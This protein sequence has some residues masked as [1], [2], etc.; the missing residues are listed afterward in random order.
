ML[1]RYSMQ[2][3]T[4]SARTIDSR[5]RFEKPQLD[6]LIDIERNRCIMC[7]R[8]VR[9][10]DEVA[11]EHLLG[12]FGRGDRNHIGT[13]GN[14]PVDN[15]FS[16]NIIDLCP[17]GC[18]TSKPF[19]FQARAWELQQVNST[20]T[21]C[22][23]GC[24][25]TAW[26]RDGK[27]MRM[28]PPVRKYGSTF[29]IDEDTTAFLCNEGRFG[30]YG[31]NS[32]D[33]ITQALR[34]EGDSVVIATWG[35]AFEQASTALAAAAKLGPDRVAILAGSRATNEEYFLLSQIART[36]LGTNQIDWRVDYATPDGA[37]AA[38]AAL[39]ASNGDLDLLAKGHYGATLV[40]GA[41]LYQGAPVIGLKIKEATRQGLTKLGILGA[42]HDGWA[43]KL[44]STAAYQTP[45]NWAGSVTALADSSAVADAD[46]ES[47]RKLA[48]DS[49]TGLIV[50]AIDLAGGALAS[51]LVPAAL[52]LADSLG[53][54]WHF[55]PVFHGRNAKGA[56]ACGA[57]SDR[58]PG[59][60]LDEDS[61]RN[62]LAELGSAVGVDAKSGL[63]APEI[64][65]RAA[66][67]K[68]DTLLLHRCDE[69]AN[70]PNQALVEKALSATPNVIIID[71]FPSAV[72]RKASV[73]LPAA[74]FF[75]TDGSMTS[76]DGTLNSL[77]KANT[78]PGEAR[79]EWRTLVALAAALGA[80]TRYG[81]AEE[82]FSDLVRCWGA[83]ARLRLG[84]LKLDGPGDESP[85]RPQPTVI[86]KRT[87]PAFKLQYTSAASRVA[88]SPAL[89]ETKADANGA[90]LRLL[91]FRGVQGGDQLGS[92]CEEFV[93]LRPHD[94]IELHPGDAS[95][96]EFAE[97]HSV[98]IKG[99]ENVLHVKLNPTLP[100]GLAY[101]ATHR[102][103]FSLKPTD[104]SLPAIELEPAGGAS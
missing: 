13:E 63:T 80:P 55:L 1:Q 37:R 26:V 50:L 86:R 14:G 52:R 34:A 58:L 23:A 27:L 49:E 19:R 96:L 56:F 46:V 100:R 12:V 103:G 25:T 20:C 57:Q 102:F 75:E 88:Q 38:G 60:R 77:G 36:A 89:V 16:G 4:G 101:A 79:E 93:E 97:G 68:I 54:G 59:G 40:I 45:E 81:S 65:E 41:D 69:L 74:L 78:P 98:R 32:P 15:I 21:L 47:L 91:W 48:G 83:P 30:N 67:G 104:G 43:A 35:E 6:P 85:Q 51:S 28:T 87:R 22:S 84:D 71:S 5:R 2:H 29:T 61:T 90:G 44:A 99:S 66:E 17:V 95:R 70:H 64:L 92:R 33:R 73:V 62:L 11:G 82:I 72:T 7:T 94:E 3:G 9:F 10:M 53:D 18:L 42:R 39:A 8:C 24:P 31:A 76:A